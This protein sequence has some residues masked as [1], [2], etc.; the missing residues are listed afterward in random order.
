MENETPLYELDN[1]TQRLLS[2][3]IEL[4]FLT[5]NL[6][7]DNKDCQV[8][9]DICFQTASRFGIHIE[10]RELDSYVE[11]NNA[12]GQALDIASMPFNITITDK[13]RK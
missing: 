7:I 2:T 3:V 11:N 8:V 6:Q 12:A 9:A 5:S 13:G 4:A 10:T 1:D